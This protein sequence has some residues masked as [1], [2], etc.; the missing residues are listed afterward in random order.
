MTNIFFLGLIFPTNHNT[1]KLHILYGHL[2]PNAV[3][4]GKDSHIK[5]EDLSAMESAGGESQ[6]A[7]G[8]DEDDDVEDEEETEYESEPS[9]MSMSGRT[10]PSYEL[11]VPQFRNLT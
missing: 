3:F 7:E 5:P 2:D 10:S 4:L 11:Q 8:E 1:V 9:F 6:A